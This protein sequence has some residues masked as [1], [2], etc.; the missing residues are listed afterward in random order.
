L[1]ASFFIGLLSQWGGTNNRSW[2]V[3]AALF[4]MVFLATYAAAQ[5]AAGGKALEGMLDKNT[6]K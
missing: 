5:I 6:G 4:S 2:K 1:G 3:L